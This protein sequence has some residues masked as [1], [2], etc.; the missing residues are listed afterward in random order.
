MEKNHTLKPFV[1]LLSPL[2]TKII[3]KKSDKNIDLTDF[4]PL[5]CM[6]WLYFCGRL[7]RF[8]IRIE[9]WFLLHWRFCWSQVYLTLERWLS[10]VRQLWLTYFDKHNLSLSWSSCF[11]FKAL[12]IL[13]R[14]RILTSCSLTRTPCG[15]LC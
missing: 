9:L 1:Y 13:P 10:P 12:Y 14:D 15:Q 11:C 5:Q 6:P 3:F 2:A 7:P 4:Y 8:S